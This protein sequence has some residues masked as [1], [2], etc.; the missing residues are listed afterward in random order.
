MAWKLTSAAV[1]AAAIASDH[2]EVLHAMGDSVRARA[3]M[4][5]ARDLLLS[6]GAKIED[7]ELHRG[8]LENVPE[9]AR[10]LALAAV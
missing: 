6:R 10:I 5:E 3:M 9:N 1:L 2:A 7:P 8:Y 4:L